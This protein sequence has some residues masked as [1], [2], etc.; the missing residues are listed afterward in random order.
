MQ[1]SDWFVVLTEP[2]QALQAV[3]RLHE[4]ELELFVP[5]IRRRVP[6]GRRGKNGHKVTRIMA[7]PMFPGY[8]FVRRR[9]IS[10]INQLIDVRGVRDV[11]RIQGRPVSLPDAAVMA[12]FRKQFEQ[13][14]EWIAETAGGKRRTASVFKRGDRVRVDDDGG[15]YA[16]FVAT[17]DKVDGKG[18]VE[19]LL[20]MIRHWLPGEMVVAA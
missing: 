18:R 15:A 13:Q 8:G 9:G 14:Q 5:V 10:D 11:M 2:Q 12:V 17:V 16:G 7:R 4:M 1:E 6:T 19:V 20:G 3:Y